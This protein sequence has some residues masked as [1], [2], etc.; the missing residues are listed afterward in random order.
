MRGNAFRA[1]SQAFLSFAAPLVSL[2]ESM[3]DLVFIRISYFGALRPGDEAHLSI[4][5]E[6]FSILR[7]R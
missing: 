6:A 4:T 3:A 5:R 7:T 1:A 2:T